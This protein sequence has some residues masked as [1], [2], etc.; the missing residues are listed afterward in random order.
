MNKEERVDR[1]SM[2]VTVA[3]LMIR[4]FGGFSVSLGDKTIPAKIWRSASAKVLFVYLTLNGPTPRE[5]LM[6]LFWPDHPTQAARD[7]LNSILRYVRNALQTLNPA[8]RAFIVYETP[9]YSFRPSCPYVVDVQEFQRQ[10]DLARRAD[11]SSPEKL[12][13]YDA[14]LQLYHGL[15]LPEFYDDWILWEQDR[16]KEL[17]LKAL[18]ELGRLYLER[19]EFRPLL[20]LAQAMLHVEPCCEAAHE[21]RLEADLALGPWVMG[22]HHYQQM[23][24]A[25]EDELGVRPNG[26]LRVLHQQLMAHQPMPC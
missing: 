2:E 19:R 17:Y 15:F 7:N 10:I 14:A 18:E 12:T 6:V 16:L 11:L 23:E 13:Y 1:G 24:Q 3:K 25:L 8:G 26:Q 9:C 22:L 21:L 5:K 20:T 4:C